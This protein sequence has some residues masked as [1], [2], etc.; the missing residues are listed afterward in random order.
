MRVR[1]LLLL[2]LFLV[3]QAFG[4]ELEDEAGPVKN[5]D[6][7]ACVNGENCNKN[8]GPNG[9]N[10]G[11]GS[12]ANIAQKAAQEAKAAEDAQQSAGQQAAHQ[13]SKIA[14]DIF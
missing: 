6:D 7:I 3:L 11:Q 13:V 9:A 4:A 12:A 14:G 1:I 5:R 8:G 10:G 2:A